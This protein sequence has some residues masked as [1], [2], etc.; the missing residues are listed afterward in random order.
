MQVCKIYFIVLS[1]IINCQNSLG[2]LYKSTKSKINSKL[3]PIKVIIDVSN[4]PCGHKMP[5]YILLKTDE[6]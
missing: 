3:Q 2:Q 5:A 1:Y 4:S 6:I